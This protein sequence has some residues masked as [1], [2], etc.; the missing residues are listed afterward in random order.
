MQI[1]CLGWALE[2]GI[3]DG[4]WGGTTPDERRVLRSV[5]R[6]TTTTGADGYDEGITQQGAE[7]LGLDLVEVGRLAPQ[8]K[9]QELGDSHSP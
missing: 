5:S 8:R 6:K 9:S 4:V 7:A 3:P 1:Q 2:D